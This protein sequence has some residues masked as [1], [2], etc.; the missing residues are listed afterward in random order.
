MG[1]DKCNCSYCREGP[2]TL[3]NIGHRD[4]LTG[5]TAESEQS[6]LLAGFIRGLMVAGHTVVGRIVVGQ[7]ANASHTRGKSTNG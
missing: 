1:A 3:G 5:G 2:A 4:G 6:A 7:M